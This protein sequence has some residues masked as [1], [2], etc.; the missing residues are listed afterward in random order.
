[1]R[2]CAV[3]SNAA[4]ILSVYNL[5]VYE[6]LFPSTS[7]PFLTVRDS[8]EELTTWLKICQVS[9]SLR[10]NFGSGKVCHVYPSFQALFMLLLVYKRQACA[11]GKKSLISIC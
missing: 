9:I 6:D 11:K 4:L 7:F 8:E 1:M 10:E 5:Y 2:L 3:R